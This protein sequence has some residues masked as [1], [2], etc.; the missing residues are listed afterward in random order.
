MV[1]NYRIKKS[2]PTMGEKVSKSR[3]RGIYGNSTNNYSFLADISCHN[4]FDF[5][6]TSVDS[7]KERDEVC[8]EKV[9]GN[10]LDFLFRVT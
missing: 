5:V 6:Y 7:S 10:I 3:M 2:N 8:Q 1:C 9:Q 4:S